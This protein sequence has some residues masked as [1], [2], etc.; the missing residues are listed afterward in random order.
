MKKEILN[1]EINVTFHR[2]C[3]ANY[4]S[5]NTLL[6]HYEKE[7]ASGDPVSEKCFICGKADKRLRNKAR[8]KLTTRVK[9]LNAAKKRQD[10]AVHL[11]MTSHLDLFAVGAKYHRSCL[12]AY[13]S[14]FSL[15]AKEKKLNEDIVTNVYD[16]SFVKLA[17]D[18]QKS[19]LS[20]DRA[21]TTLPILLSRFQNI[22]VLQGIDKNE[23]TYYSSG[24][25]RERLQKHFWERI[26]IIGHPRAT[27]V[28][29]ASDI[30]VG[31][32][33]QRIAK[34][35]EEIEVDRAE[36]ETW[37]IQVAHYLML[38]ILQ[39]YIKQ[40]AFYAIPWLTKSHQRHIEAAWKSIGSN[41]VPQ[42]L[43]NY[44]TLSAG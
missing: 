1:H 9:V 17:D 40:L 32:A 43:M 25:L 22:L 34:L 24:N 20:S 27:N 10:D 19:M 3:R 41:A 15:Q 21:V 8:E 12:A 7:E 31:E 26:S 6:A 39:S 30:T 38:M 13:L 5:K 37:N 11:R 35:Q 28:V 44:M 14:G 18:I 4:T 16:K 33:M 29:C 42:Y 23:L 36:Q 2:N